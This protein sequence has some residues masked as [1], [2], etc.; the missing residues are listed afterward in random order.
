[1]WKE[2]KKDFEWTQHKQRH[3]LNRGQV[4]KASP[5]MCASQST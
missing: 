4:W 5:Q 3:A 1:M 2:E